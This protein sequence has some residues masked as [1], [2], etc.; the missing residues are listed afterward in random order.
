MTRSIFISYCHDDAPVADKICEIIEGQ[1]IA[2][3][4][5]PRDIP[6]GERYSDEIIGAL[7]EA[8]AMVVVV[9]SASNFSTHVCSEVERAFAKK[10]KIVPFLVSTVTLSPALEYFLS[11]AQWVDAAKD[12]D[13]A[14]ELLVSAVR[15]LSPSGHSST[16]DD[17]LEVLA[18][19]IELDIDLSGNCTSRYGVTVRKLKQTPRGT[20]DIVN[21]GLFDEPIRSTP[22]DI[23]GPHDVKGEDG[24]ELVV[25]WPNLQHKESSIKRFCI[26][27]GV[28]LDVNEQY[29]YSYYVN[30]LEL[31]DC[32]QGS[33]FWDNEILDRTERIEVAVRTPNGMRID[34]ARLTVETKPVEPGFGALKHFE[35]RLLGD[36]R[37]CITY[38]LFR[39]KLGVNYVLRWDWKPDL[40]P[41]NQASCS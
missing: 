26:D 14:T 11:G 27:L 20:T 9:S 1:G 33:E 38:G 6:A 40:P 12:F 35:S 13:R 31:F 28:N 29:S 32:S 4:I 36:G 24:R 5:A 3:W 7:N 15:R 23:F 37:H 39:P 8:Q 19:T 41:E 18:D 34:N 17:S 30:E 2:C 25:I 22:I 21:E 16:E 10:L